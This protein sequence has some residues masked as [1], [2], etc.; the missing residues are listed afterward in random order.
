[1]SPILSVISCTIYYFPVW[2]NQ[3]I[4]SSPL[5]L[6]LPLF[7][8]AHS[9]SILKSTI[10]YTTLFSFFHLSFPLFISPLFL[11]FL[12]F[13]LQPISTSFFSLWLLSLRTSQ[14][15][16]RN[17]FIKKLPVTR[18]KSKNHQISEYS[19]LRTCV[20]RGNRRLYTIFLALAVLYF[21]SYT[22]LSLS[23]HYKDRCMVA[24]TA[25][26]WFSSVSRP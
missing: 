8:P 23:T 10:T 14:S 13:F 20:G 9:F 7:L 25:T 19:V 16:L 12:S 2:W 15:A 1:V 17:T 24:A 22:C 26:G 3:S 4:P 6:F 21:F 18:K 5:L 11:L